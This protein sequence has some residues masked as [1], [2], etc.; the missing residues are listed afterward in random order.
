MNKVLKKYNRLVI[1]SC[2]L[3][4]AITCNRLDYKNMSTITPD[5]VW[6][7]SIMIQGFLSDIYGRLMPGW[8]I[9]G[10]S[11][12]EALNTAISMGD[13]LRGLISVQNSGND[14]NYGNIDRINFFLDNLED[15]PESVITRNRKSQLAGEALFWRAWS[16]WHIV[17]QVGGVPL[18]LH[19]QDVTDVEALFLPRNTTSECI[20]QIIKDLDDAISTLPA[21]W[22]GTNYGRIDACA[23]WALKGRIL[24]YY[25]S[26]L[27]NPDNDQTRWQT[28]Y[29]ANS[30]ALAFLNS[31]GKGLYPKFND[32]WKDERNEEVIMVNQYWYPDHTFN[33]SCTRPEPITS[34]CSNQNQPI[35]PML[36]AFP[37]KDG[38]P[39]QFDKDRIM[40]DAAY[41]AQYLTDFVTNRD[42]RFY[43]TIFFGGTAY[44]SKD[45]GP[46]GR[47]NKPDEKYWSVWK[48]VI[49]SSTP[50]G[51]VYSHLGFVQTQVSCNYGVTGYFVIKGM[52]PDLTANTIAQSKTDWVAIRY[53]EVLMNYGECANEV[54]KASESLQVL[55]DIRKRAGILEGDGR[56]GI[57]AN[58]QQ[59][60]RE[61]YISERF[62]EFAFEGFRFH[63][64]RRW[65]RFDILNDYQYRAG[66]MITLNEGEVV[67]EQNDFD[68][69]SSIY[70]TEVRGRFHVEIVDNLAYSEDYKYN[71]SLNN[72]FYPLSLSAISSNSKLEQNNEWG[73]TFDPLK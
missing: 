40:S 58:T 51:Y 9:D 38:S 56:Y 65:K 24:M 46:E 4:V 68:W 32:I 34:G 2:M 69:T 67:N 28:A 33:Q 31:A 66:L 50:L 42:D 35:L 8:P 26:P 54:N 11:S 71:L 45:W 30:D 25:A 13:Y 16:Y 59:E 29:Q 21:T 12:D 36:N 43:S 63:D 47:F 64:L 5:N 72:W 61:A 18:I 44:P 10:N 41:N 22:S 23:A 60:I 7:D 73:G 15:V 6:K 49:D 20:A 3:F 57:T 55:Y 39:L 62:V 48:K 19:I 1:F 14:L 53:A 52:D 17:R 37:K 27:F 70:D